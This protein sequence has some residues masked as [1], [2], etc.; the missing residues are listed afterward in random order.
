MSLFPFS[1]RIGINDILSIGTNAKSILKT[2]ISN[3]TGTSLDLLI[4]SQSSTSTSSSSNDLQT[5]CEAV[6]I[7]LSDEATKVRAGQEKVLMRLVGEVMKRSKGKA[8]AK[9]VLIV[10]KDLLMK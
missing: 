1:S 3:P 10:L 2:R 4:K 9:K 8:D 6:I 7:D 5:L